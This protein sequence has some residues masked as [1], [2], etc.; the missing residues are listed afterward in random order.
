MIIKNLLLYED[1]TFN[2]VINSIEEEKNLL[3]TYFNQNSVNIYFRNEKFRN[4]IDKEFEVYQ[5]DTGVFFLLKFLGKNKIKRIN[6]TGFNI[7]IINEINKKEYSYMY[8]KW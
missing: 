1:E 2:K 6:A 4:L 5:A 3:L 8:H 7:K